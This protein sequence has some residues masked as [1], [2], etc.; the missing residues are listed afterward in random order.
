[1]RGVF[2]IL[3]LGTGGAAAET[4]DLST[5]TI[6]DINAAFDAGTLTSE[7]LVELCLQRIAAYDEAGPKLNAILALN[8]KALD[9]RAL[10][11]RSARRRVAGRRSTA[12]PWFSKTTSTPGTFPPRPD[13]S[14][15]QARCHRMTP[16]S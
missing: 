1:L 8:A 6:A 14:C 3:L 13:P 16:S 7:K 2:L 4:L 10:S 11:T 5:A 9:E 12:S 15:W